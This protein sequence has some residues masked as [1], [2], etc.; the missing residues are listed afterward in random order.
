MTGA[1]L[2]NGA[3]LNSRPDTRHRRLSGERVYLWTSYMLP[4]TMEYHLRCDTCDFDRHISDNGRPYTMAKEHERD[5][6]N[7]FVLMEIIQD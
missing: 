1:S 6:D 5:H 3:E 2:P 7:H 4:I